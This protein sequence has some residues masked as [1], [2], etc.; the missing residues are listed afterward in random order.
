MVWPIF[1]G[2]SPCNVRHQ[3]G[4]Y[5]ESLAMHKER[6]KNNK[7]KAHKWKLALI[8]AANLSGSHFNQ[9]YSPISYMN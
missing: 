6:F 1:Y 9:G 2:V 3:K 4:S 5:G 8:E 7:E